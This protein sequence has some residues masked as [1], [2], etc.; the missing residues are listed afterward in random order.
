MF[1]KTAA[2]EIKGRFGGRKL[3]LEEILW[4]GEIVHPTVGVHV[5]I[6]MDWQDSY[7]IL[8]W[9]LAHVYF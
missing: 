5:D 7:S 2:F 9:V 4:F 3:E 6:A 1:R 8:G